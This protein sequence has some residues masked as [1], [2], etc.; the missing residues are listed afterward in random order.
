MRVDRIVREVCGGCIQEV[1]AGRW[2]A[3]VVVVEAII[4]VGRLSLST[5]G[6]AIAGPT[7][8]KHAIKR[9]DRLLGNGHLHAE[10]WIVFAA[11]ARWL[12]R[13]LHRPV[14]LVDWTKAAEGFYALVAAVPIGGRAVPIY[15]EVHRDSLQGNHRVHVAFLRSLAAILPPNCTPILVSDAGFQG[16]FF[17]AVLKMGWDFVGRIRGTAK[18]R[19]PSGGRPVTKAHLY[20]QAT[21]VLRAE[22]HRTR[23]PRQ[24]QAEAWSPSRVHHRDRGRNT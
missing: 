10:R 7:M 9:V 15:E 21:A 24:G 18:L 5:I 2:Q 14:V 8:P 13:D 22:S 3:I 16:P 1:H 20:A 4:A 19:F 17:R 23:R 6:R 12:L 11:L